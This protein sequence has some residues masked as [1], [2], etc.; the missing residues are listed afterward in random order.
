MKQIV[1]KL[2]DILLRFYDEIFAGIWMVAVII[3][4]DAVLYKFF[5]GIPSYPIGTYYWIFLGFYTTFFVIAGALI[6][7]IKKYRLQKTLN[8]LE[9]INKITNYQKR[10]I[11]AI[12]GNLSSYQG[13]LTKEGFLNFLM[14]NLFEFGVM[15]SWFGIE[16]FIDNILCGITLVVPMIYIALFFA[17]LCLQGFLDDYI[18]QQLSLKTKRKGFNNLCY[19]SK[20]LMLQLIED[21][22]GGSNNDKIGEL[23]LEQT[24]EDIGAIIQISSEKDYKKSHYIVRK[25]KKSFK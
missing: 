12:V 16:G 3:P 2:A 6:P 17:F 8:K 15:F 4:V 10:K 21:I 23:L 7:V 13:I 1:H 19:A 18:A 5:T 9:K 20:T 24:I 25:I 22:G 11:F 14:A